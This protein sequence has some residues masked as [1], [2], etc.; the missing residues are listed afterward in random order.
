MRRLRTRALSNL[1]RTSTATSETQTDTELNFARANNKALPAGT[2][3]K[4]TGTLTI[5][6]DGVY[7]LAL[8]TRGTTG[9]VELDGTRIPGGGGGGR[10]GGAQAGATPPPALPP[11]VAALRGQHP[12]T[13]SIVPTVDKLNN[14][15][16][17][18]ELKAGAHQ[19]AV[20]S[21]GEAFGNPMQIRL[22][23]V[24][25]DQEKA[26]YDAAIAAAKQAKKAVVFAWGRDRPETFQLTPQ[27]TR[28]IQDVASV[29]ANT[30]VVL[31]TSLP[32]A[33]PWLQSW[34]IATNRWETAT[35][36]RPVFVG[37]SSRDLRLQGEVTIAR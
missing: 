31:S 3:W 9:V 10:G 28:L 17:K 29:N 15:R 13:G 11:A 34:S 8:Q 2:S 35:G 36:P 4:W 37:A 6:T 33:M 18:I 12:I 21:T 25:P 30:V 1:T 32:V 16:A 5:P 27:Q 20:T 24:T 22:A 23:W 26:T 19:L 7:T 14:A